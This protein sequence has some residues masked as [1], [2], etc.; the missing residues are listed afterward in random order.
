MTLP[1]SDYKKPLPRI[2][3]SNAPFWKAAKA[4]ELKLP[5]CTDCRHWVFPIAPWC[6]RCWSE[7]LE[8]EKLSG[9]GKISSWVIV[10]RA[11]DP[12]FEADVP[13]MVVQ[14]DLEEGMRFISNVVDVSIAE[15][16][17]DMPVTAIFEDVTPEISLVKFRRRM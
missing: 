2:T 6:Q 15:I 3:A 8:W 5:R 7:N 12:S 9:R 17:A 1:H 14:V 4:H 16:H 13:Y 10:R 11:F